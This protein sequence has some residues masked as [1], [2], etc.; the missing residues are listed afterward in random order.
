MPA[1]LRP[2]TL[3]SW[4]AGK[5]LRRP[6]LMLIA[7][8]SLSAIALAIAVGGTACA[9]VLGAAALLVARARPSTAQIRAIVRE[10]NAPIEAALADLARTL[11]VRGP[12]SDSGIAAADLDD[13]LA[14]VLAAARRLHGADAAAL[15]VDRGDGG[16]PHLATS[17]LAEPPPDPASLRLAA[18]GARAVAASY[19]HG[20][21]A[22]EAIR[23]SLAVPLRIDDEERD[24]T[25]TVFWRDR[26]R[27]PSDDD[28][29]L[30]EDLAARAARAIADAL[31]AHRISASS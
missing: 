2:T 17:G 19:R 15:V 27:E 8:H 25:L 14:R 23:S 7:D 6:I 21:E 30:L 18:P 11:S 20:E 9:L 5:R 13:V 24:G 4:P 31:R 28:V 12:H 1:I 26:A 16:Q 29:A 10:S 3:L 22:P